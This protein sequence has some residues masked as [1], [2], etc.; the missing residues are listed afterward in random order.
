VVFFFLFAREEPLCHRSTSYSTVRPGLA[1]CNAGGRRVFGRGRRLWL[2][3]WRWRWLLAE[4][5]P[6]RKRHA[7]LKKVGALPH[8]Q[9]LAGCVGTARASADARKG[10]ATLLTRRRKSK[11]HQRQVLAW[12]HGRWQ[13][14]PSEKGHIFALTI[15]CLGQR[16]LNENLSSKCVGVNILVNLCQVTELEFSPFPARS[17]VNC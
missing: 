7:P 10:E 8:L 6:K 9:Y 1:P 2:W 15:K 16:I 12:M 17:D 14:V 3:L 13:A 4:E 11:R 5:W